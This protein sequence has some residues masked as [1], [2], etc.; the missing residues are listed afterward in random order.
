MRLQ[1]ANNELIEVQGTATIHLL[2]GGQQFQWEAFVAPI[3]D[4]GILGYDFLYFYD[5]V[6][7]A[8][9]GIRIAGKWTQWTV[10]GAP[11]CAN[12][13][14]LKQN[15]TIPAY[16]EWVAEGIAT[17]HKLCSDFAVVEPASKDDFEGN[18]VIGR[19][20]IDPSRTD[21]GIPIRLMN[22]SA[23]NIELR[24]GTTLGYL[25]EVETIE[26]IAEQ[27]NCELEHFYRVARVCRA[28][29]RPESCTV[30]GPAV[31]SALNTPSPDSWPEELQ[32]LYDRSRE[33][34]PPHKQ[35]RL[36]ELLNKHAN[37]FAKSPEDLGRTSVVQHTIDTGDAR[38]IRQP[39]R[40]PPKA[41]Q[42]E[43]E[44][45]LDSQLKAGVIKESTSPWA[46]PMVFVRK[47][48]G[49]TRPC[50]DYRK[51][52]DVTRRDAY[53]LPRVDDCL[54]CLSGAKLFSTLDLQSG[55][56]QI[57]VKP[58]DRPKTA[59]VTRS[60]LYEYV[61]MPFGLCNAPSTFERCMELVLKGLQWRTLLIYLDDIIILSSTFTEHIERLDEVLRRLGNAG[62]KLKPSKCELFREEVLFLG[63]II[64]QDGVKPDP[65]KVS[66]VQNWPIPRN[67]TDVRSFL[68]L[69]SYYRRFIAKFSTIAGPLHRLLEAGQT[70]EWTPNCQA[71]FEALKAALTGNEVMSYPN[72]DG[73][74][75]IDTDAS[76][77]GIGATLSQLQWCD[78][79][80]REEERPIAYASRS[81]TKTQRR[82][83]TTRRELLAIVTFVQHFRH[84]LLGKQ[85][86][87]RTD[88]SALRWIMSFRDPVDQMARWLEI[89]AQFDFKIEHRAGKKHGNADAL[90]RVPC[91]P[92]DCPCYD[93]RT[94]LTELPC[95][96]CDKCVAK[97]E[98]W[99][100]FN[101][102][103]DVIP[104]AARRIATAELQPPQNTANEHESL[105]DD[106]SPD[107]TPEP[108]KPASLATV[109][110][111]M[112]TVVTLLLGD[113]CNLGELIR[114]S[115]NRFTGDYKKR[116]LERRSA[117]MDSPTSGE[118]PGQIPLSTAIRVVRPPRLS[119]DLPENP[120][121][122]VRTETN[123]NMPSAPD[124]GALAGP[125]AGD[126]SD[127]T[128]EPD[129]RDDGDAQRDA[130]PA[131]A[132]STG[133]SAGRTTSWVNGYTSEEIAQMQRADPDLKTVLDWLDKSPQRPSRDMVA[134]HSP[135]TRNLW[136]LWQQLVLQNGVLY[137]RWETS[138]R[139]KSY[140]QLVV[141][142]QL[143]ST[144]L[145][146]CHNSI[147]SAHLGVKKTIK[148]TKRQ[149]YWY[150]LKESVREWIKKCAKCGARK[151]P[152][153]TPRAPLGD[154]HVGA[155][156]DRLVTDILGPLPVTERG[157]KYILLV[158]D[159]FTRWM[160]A[161]PIPDQTAETV[162][163]RVVYDFI[164]RFGA[165]LDIHSDQGRTYESN[166][167]KQVCKLLDIHKT[168]TTPYHPSSNGQAERFNQVLVNMIAAYVDEDQRNWDAHLPLLTS[169]YRSCEHETTGYTPNMLMLGRETHAPINLLLGCSTTD[170][171]Q[172]DECDYV[173]SLRERMTTIHHLTRK[174]LGKS[175]IRQKRD[176]DPRVAHH[177][178]AIG[179][180][181]YVR[182]STKTPGLSPKLKPAQWKGPC[183]IQ[184]VLSDLLF[185]IRSKQRGKATI[186]HHDRLKRYYS[187]DVPQWMRDLQKNL[188]R[189]GSP[190]GTTDLSPNLQETACTDNGN[191]SNRH[192]S[193]AEAAVTPSTRTEAP[194][195]P[196]PRRSSRTTRQPVRYRDFV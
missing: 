108:A 11:P 168:R 62:L 171:D 28:H 118:T 195:Q 16:S 167:F 166:L 104:L 192:Q 180:L 106:V 92:D 45:V 134:R 181:V 85:F 91:D 133:F 23:E 177:N 39:P 141:P 160:E 86:L 172:V 100:D 179:D 56:W 193:P 140:L 44:K 127:V 83:C 110:M 67:V 78:Q 152:Q 21:I 103:D 109:L 79:S 185:E 8:R 37:T 81:M 12:K 34:L 68:G 10:K 147:T 20:L 149:F 161:Y 178:Y 31:P 124:E 69:C 9:R 122:T 132:A 190:S 148:K 57:E 196:P 113:V 84:Y 7:E 135:A 156:M 102:V 95:G 136:L 116:T 157:N 6:L 93:G 96:G 126:R 48:D 41:F 90:S 114:R 191:I 18:F 162:A 173:S 82:Y 154:Y 129:D 183:I 25:H 150:R 65:S 89:M 169:A 187:D 182:D 72:K 59:F 97:S 98:L 94:I 58:E 75:I 158:G 188:L 131:V 66:A 30:N 105:G 145:Q 1:T 33:D 15:T 50:V 115:C 88:H 52:N 38:P 174:H 143:Q 77:T 130:A 19:S 128:G 123:C 170:E 159:H 107:A 13:V 80:Q 101:K 5:C 121:D 27:E 163:H 47:K 4:D 194:T 36:R 74:F 186:L 153:K 55:Y 120:P 165:P 71:A 40:R 112:A 175:A 14:S 24:A 155:P 54:D 142:Q 144:V 70:F 35:E 119:T 29:T 137:K 151:R 73:L 32:K 176:H 26:L 138:D 3:S 76:D 189:N 42:G 17:N 43:E 111:L 2:I 61:T 146:A 22:P 99:S 184:R 51:L 49:T 87:I 60:G 63:H 46:S 139:T 117:N 125:R 53:P 64:T 164:S